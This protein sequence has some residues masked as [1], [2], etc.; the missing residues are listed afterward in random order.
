M[1]DSAEDKKPPDD[2]AEGAGKGKDVEEKKKPTEFWIS[3]D[4][5]ARR[6]Y[7]SKWIA[8]SSSKDRT[9]KIWELNSME[10]RGTLG[11]YHEGGVRCCAVDRESLSAI[12][13]GDDGSMCLWAMDRYECKEQWLSSK[14][15]QQTCIAAHFE[16]E[17]AVTGTA[18]GML[19]FWDTTRMGLKAVVPAHQGARINKIVFDGGLGHSL[20]ASTDGRVR[21]WDVNDADGPKCIGTFDRHGDNVTALFVDFRRNRVLSGASDGSLFFWHLTSRAIIAEL[22]GHRDKINKADCNVDMGMAITVSDD[23]TARIWE[24]P[25]GNPLGTLSGHTLAVRDVAVN[26]EENICITCSDDTTLRIWDLV[27]RACLA[28][29]EGHQ[30]RVTC[31]NANWKKHQILSGSDDCTLKLWDT[32]KWWCEETLYGHSGPITMIA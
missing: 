17:R 30:D 6:V 1:A 5:L 23:E 3:W 11:G 25:S 28:V 4:S 10:C 13:A 8:V 22:T 21:K 7:L 29:L 26:Y 2:Q 12:T 14:Y 27:G 31:L 16:H 18:T 15:G 24:M 9:A 20:T 32:E 19:L